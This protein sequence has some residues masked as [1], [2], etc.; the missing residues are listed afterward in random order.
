MEQSA[1]K[2]TGDHVIYRT[3]D[4][5]EDYSFYVLKQKDRCYC[6]YIEHQ[7]SYN[8]RPS[9]SH[10]THR[11]YDST[12]GLYYIDLSVWKPRTLQSALKVAKL[13]AEATESYR[14]QGVRF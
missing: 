12:L 14:K 9:D 2:T 10:S 8:E 3:K 5:T 13:W 4:N 11:S 6:V 7:P 1:E